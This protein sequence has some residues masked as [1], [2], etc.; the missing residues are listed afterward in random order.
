MKLE[1]KLLRCREDQTNVFEINAN[2]KEKIAGE[3]KV[4]NLLEQS[5]KTNN[6]I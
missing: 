6:F 2:K 4:L 5:V 1:T 3:R